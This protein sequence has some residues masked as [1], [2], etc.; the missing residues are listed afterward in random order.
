ME[1]KPRLF[2]CAASNCGIEIGATDQ[3]PA[4]ISHDGE[5]WLCER[6]YRTEKYEDTDLTPTDCEECRET[7]RGAYGLEIHNRRKH[8]DGSRKRV[9]KSDRVI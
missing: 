3:P 6:N 5:K 9:R 4:K 8:N 2:I 1:T 7:F